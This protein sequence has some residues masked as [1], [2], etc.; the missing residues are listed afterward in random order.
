MPAKN[1]KPIDQ[2]KDTAVSGLSYL[3]LF[4]AKDYASSKLFEACHAD[5]ELIPAWVLG[6][7][8]AKLIVKTMDSNAYDM[9]ATA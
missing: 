1:D 4:V 6:P 9:E 8:L 7:D 5:P 3:R 2:S